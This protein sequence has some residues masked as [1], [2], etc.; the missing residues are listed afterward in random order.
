MSIKKFLLF[1]GL[2][3]ILAGCGGVDKYDTNYTGYDTTA[4]SN[5]IEPGLYPERP[6]EGQLLQLH[7]QSRHVRGERTATAGERYVF[8]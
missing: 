2:T 6:E 5:P 1:F 4:T 8:P 3:A 7:V